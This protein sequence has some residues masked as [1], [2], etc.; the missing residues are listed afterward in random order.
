MKS[1]RKSSS[2]NNNTNS[3]IA[4]AEEAIAGIATSAVAVEAEDVATTV[5]AVGV[6]EVDRCSLKAIKHTK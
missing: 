2:S 1:L 4:A 5:V 3:Q 6:G